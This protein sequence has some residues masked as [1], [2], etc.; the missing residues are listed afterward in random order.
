MPNPQLLLQPELHPK[1]LE[2]YNAVVEKKKRG[3][4][5]FILGGGAQSGKTIVNVEVCKGLI[6]EKMQRTLNGEPPG[7]AWFVAPTFPLLDRLYETFKARIPESW[8]REWRAQKKEWVL[9]TGDRIKLRSAKNPQDLRSDDCFLV[10]YDELSRG[11]E[12]SFLN[13]CT[14]LVAHSGIFV[15]TTTPCNA[16]SPWLTE[17]YYTHQDDPAYHWGHQR[18][19]DNL[20][21]TLEDIS[22][23][24]KRFPAQFGEEELD[25]RFL[26][27]RVGLVYDNF[28][29]K[30]HIIEE[31][32]PT[33]ND[34]IVAGLD[35]GSNHPFVYLRAALHPGGGMTVFSE[36]YMQKAAPSDVVDIIRRDPIEQRIKRRWADPSGA[37]T[38]NEFHKAGLATLGAK[39]DVH[40]GIRATYA[41]IQAHGCFRVTRDCHN[42]IREFGLYRYKSDTPGKKGDQPYKINDD[43][44]DCVRYIALG[45]NVGLRSRVVS[46]TGA[47]SKRGKPESKPYLDFDLYKKTGKFY[48]AGVPR[49]KPPDEKKSL[50]EAGGRPW[51]MN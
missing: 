25:G 20:D 35:Q 2:F 18:I 16:E 36:L 19:E 12:E 31:Y 21:I 27:S 9:V 51:H 50:W 13:S 32:T 22:Q 41:L 30:K 1:Q 29:A 40:E 28:D 15:A 26:R 46:V 38:R 48:I 7:I 4:R 24:R 47:E 34:V 3:V 49:P 39:N 33:D 11:Q 14:R 10:S 43:G 45:E 17:E 23:L 42:L 5:K 8:V 37:V 6:G 44:M